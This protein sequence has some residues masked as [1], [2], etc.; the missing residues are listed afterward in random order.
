MGIHAAV[1][2]FI[3]A[4][5]FEGL[6]SCGSVEYCRGIAG[7]Q[8][9]LLLIVGSAE[10]FGNIELG[11]MEICNEKQGAEQCSSV[12]QSHG[13]L[14]YGQAQGIH[15]GEDDGSAG[16]RQTPVALGTAALAALAVDF[17]HVEK[18][19]ADQCAQYIKQQNENAEPG[20]HAAEVKENGREYAKTDDVAQ[21]I[22]LNAE[23]LLVFGATF[24]AAG[25]YTVE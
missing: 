7:L 21:R 15:N 12:I 16:H 23:I 17:Q 8:C 22:Q 4:L 6:P 5:I 9:I 10:E 25:H 18:S 24:F 20:V 2:V 3:D 19:Q 13:N 11:N 14:R 1:V